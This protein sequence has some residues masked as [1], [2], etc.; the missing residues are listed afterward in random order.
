MAETD[1]KSI[2]LIRHGESQSQANPDVDG[3]NPDLSPRGE[4][5]AKLL[6]NRVADLA[7]DVVIVS[8]LIRAY[9]THKL[10][11]LQCS[12]VHFDPRLVESDWGHPKRFVGVEFG[13][14]DGS[15]ILV[16]PDAH[17]LPVAERMRSLVDS[18]AASELKNFVLFGH[19][20]VFAEFLGC[21][22][23]VGVESAR[24]A[25]MENTALSTLEIRENDKRCLIQWNDATHLAAL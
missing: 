25:L 10:S 19:W 13:Y 8:P 21:F 1:T 14:L 15:G 17:L 23:E 4:Q 9:R 2:I 12:T 11:Q 20:G 22:L 5:Q 24:M 3:M 7:P 6:R 18:I 16:E